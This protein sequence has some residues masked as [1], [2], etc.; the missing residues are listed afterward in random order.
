MKTRGGRR[1]TH[2]VWGVA[3]LTLLCTL[4]ELRAGDEPPAIPR[5]DFSR[6]QSCPVLRVVSGDTIIVRVDQTSQRIG[7][8]GIDA[9]PL[10]KPFGPAARQY[11]R[12]LLA[13]EQVYIEYATESPEADRAGR[14][15]ANVYRAPDGLWVNLELVRQGY[16]QVAPEPRFAH[17]ALFE[18]YAARAKELKKGQW[19]EPPTTASAPRVSTTQPSDGAPGKRDKPAT[20]DTTVY[21]TPQGKKY[22]REGCY[23]LPKNATSLALKDAKARSYEPCSH[24]KPPR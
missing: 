12:D 21:V 16:A 3:T 8:I 2:R 17:Q 14:Y 1:P 9:P 20:P 10:S 6:S 7:L 18:H 13:G 4:C 19:G 5:P 23:H 22:H 15:A 24:C 11:L